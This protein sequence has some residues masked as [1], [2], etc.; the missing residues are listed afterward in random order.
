M[1]GRLLTM[2]EWHGMTHSYY[3]NARHA[4]CASHDNADSAT[5]NFVS[6]SCPFLTLPEA[7]ECAHEVTLAA[8]PHSGYPK[9]YAEAMRRPDAHLYHEAACKEIDALLDNGTWDLARLT[10]G[11]EGVGG[12]W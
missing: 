10:T 3:V 7:L 8:S 12:E 5:V 11:G 2:M 6:E 4:G 1:L 9:S